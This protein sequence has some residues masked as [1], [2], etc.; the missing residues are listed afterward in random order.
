MALSYM[1][2]LSYSLLQ[3]GSHNWAPK[4]GEI[5]QFVVWKQGIMQYILKRE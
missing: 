4:Y 1:Y 5:V 2:V 3:S